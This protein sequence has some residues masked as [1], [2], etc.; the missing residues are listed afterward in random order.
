MRKRWVVL[1]ILAESIVVFSSVG[2]AIHAAG[3]K[4][5]NAFFVVLLGQ[6]ALVV[7]AKAGELT[8]A[9]RMAGGALAIGAA[10]VE[11]EGMVEVSGQPT[12]GIV[13]GGA[14]LIKMIGR[15][16]ACVAAGAVGGADCAVVETG[17]LPGAGIVTG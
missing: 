15:A 17:R 13:A 10:M 2:M 6:L 16:V 1:P 4:I 14:L 7:A 9:G 11:R 12:T 3:C 5:G 8:A